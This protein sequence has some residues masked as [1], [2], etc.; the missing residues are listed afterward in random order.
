MRVI[1]FL[2]Q[3]FHQFF[4]SLLH[5][6]HFSVNQPIHSVDVLFNTLITVVN[7]S[8]SVEFVLQSAENTIGT[9][10]FLLCLTVKRNI[11]V[12]LQTPNRVFRPD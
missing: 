10:Q 3:T 7:R 11:T 12:V 2:N 5:R 1:L 9:Q 4:I 6:V 8:D